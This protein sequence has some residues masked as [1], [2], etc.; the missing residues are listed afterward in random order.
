M[1]SDKAIA[2]LRSVLNGALNHIQSAFDSDRNI[3]SEQT[4]AW[5]KENHS[6]VRRIEAVLRGTETTSQ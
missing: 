5:I 6:I 1:Q 2:D 3:K 4:R